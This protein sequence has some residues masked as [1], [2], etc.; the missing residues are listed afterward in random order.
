MRMPTESSDTISKR[1]KAAMP[2]RTWSD[3]SEMPKAPVWIGGSGCDAGRNAAA[4]E[5]LDANAAFLTGRGHEIGQE[6]QRFGELDPLRLNAEFDLSALVEIKAGLAERQDRLAGADDPPVAEDAAVHLSL[7]AVDA[8]RQARL[9]CEFRGVDDD[10]HR[11]EA[12]QR[13][14]LGER[15]IEIGFHPG[16]H[17]RLVESM[18]DHVEIGKPTRCRRPLKSI[19]PMSGSRSDTEGPLSFSGMS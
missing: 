11:S 1:G 14:R 10:L 16:A 6:A 4:D 8:G 13:R 2:N 12:Q 9:R 5:G 3:R 15:H 7:G 19:P 18:A 17:G